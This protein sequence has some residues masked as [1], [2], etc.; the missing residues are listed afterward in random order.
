MHPEDACAIHVGVHKFKFTQLHDVLSFVMRQTRQCKHCEQIFE[1]S[2]GKVFANHVRWCPKNTTNGDKGVSKSSKTLRD[3]S[4]ERKGVLTEFSVQCHKCL[5]KFNVIE[6]KNEHPKK[7]KYF[8]DRG[9]ANS[10]VIS[11]EQKQIVSEKLQKYP[12][13]K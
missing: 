1:N 5:D 13:L 12:Q 9:C 4:L 3:R 7:E 11:E 2:E 10:H 8:C 6:L